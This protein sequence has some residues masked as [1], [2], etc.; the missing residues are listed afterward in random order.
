MANQSKQFPDLEIPKIQAYLQDIILQLDGPIA[1]GIFRYSLHSLSPPLL[2][3]LW[4]DRVSVNVTENQGYKKQL[5]QG[6]YQLAGNSGDMRLHA[7][8]L[9]KMWLRELPGPLIPIYL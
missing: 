1:E 2:V 4:N 9:L 8:S 3:Y 5:D 6:V 7:A